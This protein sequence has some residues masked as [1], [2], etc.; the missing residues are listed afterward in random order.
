MP[1]HYSGKKKTSVS[2]NGEMWNEWM[3]FCLDRYGS[4]RRAS[5]ELERA[6]K[7]YLQLQHHLEGLRT[8]DEF[9]EELK[10]V[11]EGLHKLV[12]K[13]SLDEKTIK[14][15]ILLQSMIDLG[16]IRYEEQS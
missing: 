3:K 2:I 7:H 14:R 11:R 10:T 1:R 5:S 6:I 16:L 13:L 12:Q 4:S 15:M 9:D 8:H